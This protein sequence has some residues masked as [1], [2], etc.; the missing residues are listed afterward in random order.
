MVS[1]DSGIHY[2]PNQVIYGLSKHGMNDLVQYILAEYKQYNI[3]AV[4]LCPGLTD[5]EMG[6]GLKPTV[7]E[8]VLSRENIAEWAKWVIIQADNLNV[9]GP[10][11]LSPMR[12]PWE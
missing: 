1:S 7:R 3:H 8:N 4:S 9:A 12:N 11:I 6:L 5:T 2:F 10:M